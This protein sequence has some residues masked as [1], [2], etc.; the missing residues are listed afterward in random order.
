MPLLETAET[1]VVLGS[2]YWRL[3]GRARVREAADKVNAGSERAGRA[4]PGLP[5]EP[6]PR[7]FRRHVNGAD[8]PLQKPSHYS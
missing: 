2:C 3:C 4:R 5:G 1:D 7:D 6:G 8:K